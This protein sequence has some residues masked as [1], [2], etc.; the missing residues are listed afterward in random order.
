[1][2]TD[3][4]SFGIPSPPTK[5]PVAICLHLHP[6]ERLKI[7]NPQTQLSPVI[8]AQKSMGPRNLRAMS[9]VK[10]QKEP[11]HQRTCFR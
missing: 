11:P 5:S 7:K 8:Q 1:M 6:E 9:L 2:A 4:V 10:K 3:G